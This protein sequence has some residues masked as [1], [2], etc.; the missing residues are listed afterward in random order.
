MLVCSVGES[1]HT[2]V[3]CHSDKCWP[4]QAGPG[5]RAHHQHHTITVDQISGSVDIRQ[6]VTVTTVMKYDTTMAALTTPFASLMP[7]HLHSEM[8]T[9]RQL[10]SKLELQQDCDDEV[11]DDPKVNLESSE[12]WEQFHDIGTEMV[13]TKSGR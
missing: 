7:P 2:G 1:R 13:I 11:D 10:R 6:S 5:G 12:L 9:L 8:E 3:V 4:G